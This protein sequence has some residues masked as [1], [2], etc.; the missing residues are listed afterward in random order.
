MKERGRLAVPIGA[1]AIAFVFHALCNAHY[2]F[3]R[4]ELYFIICGRH[5]DWGYVDQPPVAPLLAAGTQVFGNSLFLLRLVPALFSAASV[6]VTGM[7]AIELG[8]GVFAQVLAATAAMF[9]PVLMSFGMK[10]SPDTIGLWTW[11]LAA[12]F[13]VRMAKGECQRLWLL[14]GAI[15]GISLQSK[16][17]VLFFIAALLLG[18]LLTPQRRLMFSKWFAGGVVLAALIAL[19]NFLWQ[20]AHHFPMIELLRNGQ[21]GKNVMVPPLV[22][23]AQQFLLTNPFLWPVWVSGL[24]WLLVRPLT[25]FLGIAYIAL[26][27]MMIATHAKHY[28]PADVY[29]ILIAAGGVAIEQWT[30]RAGAWR[31]AIAA[32]AFAL[33]V[34]F[35]PLVEPVLPEQTFIGYSNAI[36]GLM[37][38]SSNS[39]KTENNQIGVLPQDFADMHGWP[40][41]AQTIARVYDSLPPAERADAVAV[42]QNYGEAS[43]VAFFEPHVPVISGHNQYWLWGTLG[44]DGNVVIDVAGDCGAKEHL[45]RSST[46]AAVFSAPYVMPY[47]DNI[48][49]MLCRGLKTPLAQ[50]W[51]S[52]KA[53]E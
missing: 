31:A 36:L 1:A 14:V 46:R 39:M 13:V 27:A 25:R 47:E 5:P 50:L 3:F 6:Y 33:G 32:V 10:V 53:Y 52:L 8:G 16:Y 9:A 11:P 49:I 12:L 44:H 51:P 22:F 42:T 4:D 17:S 7:L 37:H 24:V 34:V 26:M 30:M 29:P 40:E 28:Y 35:V 48:P 43:A 2:G 18:L 41:M 19:P 38:I 45:F 23:I 15:F 20:A 21:Q